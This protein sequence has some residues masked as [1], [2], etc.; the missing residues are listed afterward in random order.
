[1]ASVE[2]RYDRLDVEAILA[3]LFDIKTDVRDIRDYL[4][5]EHDG[6]EEEEVDS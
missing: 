3:A 1:M 2:P 6:E 4:L 5:G